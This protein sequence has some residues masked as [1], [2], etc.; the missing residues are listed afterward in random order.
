MGHLHFLDFTVQVVIAD[1]LGVKVEQADLGLHWG[2][3]L[4]AEHGIDLGRILAFGEGDSNNPVEGVQLNRVEIVGAYN[5]PLL[6]FLLLI[7]DKGTPP[8]DMFL[9]L[10][11]LAFNLFK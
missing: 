6:D 3:V 8:E 2:L 5:F 11:L 10:F 4:V 7:L 9:E 1:L